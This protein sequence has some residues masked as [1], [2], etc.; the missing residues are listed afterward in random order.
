MEAR[1]KRNI[2]TNNKGGVGMR[3]TGL[4]GVIRKL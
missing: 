1:G 2:E 4:G 3:I